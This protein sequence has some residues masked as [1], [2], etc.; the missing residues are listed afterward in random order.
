MKFNLPAQILISKLKIQ[1]LDTP[2]VWDNKVNH[3]IVAENLVCASVAEQGVVD[4]AESF[5]AVAN[6][7][8]T[9]VKRIVKI[10]ARPIDLPH[11]NL[12]ITA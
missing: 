4:V 7:L 5:I 8:I 3:R 10:N 2:L 1:I 6:G 12:I 9:V 11:C